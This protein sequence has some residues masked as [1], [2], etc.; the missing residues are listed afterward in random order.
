MKRGVRRHR[1]PG[2][3]PVPGE[4]ERKRRCGWRSGEM[5]Q[6]TKNICLIVTV[7]SLSSTALEGFHVDSV[8][9]CRM[10]FDPT[11]TAWPDRPNKHCLGIEL[12]LDDECS[13]ASHE[14]QH[15]DKQTIQPSL[16]ALR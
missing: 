6:V 1:R 15:E 16:T 10:D 4:R 8:N 12:P 2:E 9:S 11:T 5:Y 14:I 3:A 13:L 7:V